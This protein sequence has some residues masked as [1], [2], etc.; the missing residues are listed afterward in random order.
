M[1]RAACARMD[2]GLGVA[3]AIGLVTACGGAAEGQETIRLEPVVDGLVRPV[4]VT[5][6]GDG[7]GRLFVVEQEGFVLVL[8]ADGLEEE[9]FLDLSQK[10]LCCGERGLLG[11]AFHPSFPDDPRLFV[12][13]TRRPDGATVVSELTVGDSGRPNP[14][15]ERVL[16]TIGQPFSNHNGGMIAFGLGGRLL[17]G[18]GDGGSGGDPQ[19]HAQNPNSLLGKMLRIGVNG[20][21]P[22]AIPANNPYA[23]GGGRPE[24]FAIGLRNPWRFSVDRETGKLYVGDVGQNAV[25]EIDIIRRGGN[26]GWRHFEGTRPYRPAGGIDRSTLEMPITEYAHEG[27]RCSVTGGYVYR[28]QAV[29]ELVGTYLYGD[30]CSGEIFGLRDGRQSLLLSSGMRISSFGED[31]AGEVYVVDHGGAIHRIAAASAP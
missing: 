17:V 21:L 15:S 1:T 2:G 26:Y 14:G 13:Y 30:Y 22:Y 6:A 5:H 4:F 31:E 24:I 11:L 10:V 19:N 18:M 25:E 8:G 29:P 23:A 16:L 3:L 27:G 7:S 9:P 28:G 20:R 12:D